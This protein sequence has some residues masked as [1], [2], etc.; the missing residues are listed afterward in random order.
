MRSWPTQQDK[1]QHPRS[2]RVISGARFS[3]A[4]CGPQ[5]LP[6]GRGLGAA[7][8][9]EV[10]PLLQLEVGEHQRDGVPGLGQDGPRAV[11]VVLV[12]GGEVG[13]A[14]SAARPP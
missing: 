11:S 7:D 12:F 9:Q 8:L 3:H 1:E 14:D 6:D 5:H 13:A 2:P 4:G 10:V